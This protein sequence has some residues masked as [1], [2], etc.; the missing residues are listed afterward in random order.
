[1]NLLFLTPRP[2]EPPDRGDKIRSHHLARRLA[3][4]HRV[5]LGFLVA[6][7][8]EREAAAVAATWAASVHWVRRARWQ[9]AAGAARA[10]GTGEPLTFGYFR[11]TDLARRLRDV[12]AAERIDA[13][14]VCGS[15]MAPYVEGMDVPIVLDL[16]DVDSEKW[17]AFADASRFARQ[18]VY[19]LEHRRLR[20]REAELVERVAHTI[21]CSA[22]ERDSLVEF[23][24]GGPVSVVENGVEL[25]A[26]TSP[27]G[28]AERSGI[29]F[30]GALD[31]LPNVDGID[32][33][34][35]VVLPQVRSMLPSTTLT[36]VGRNPNRR[37]RRL[38]RLD[39]VEV[40]GGVDDPRPFVWRAA[41]AVAPL[42]LGRGVQNKVLEAM[43]AG[44]PVVA[45]R[46]AHD[47]IPTAIPGVHLES[48]DSAVGAADAVVGLLRR[49]DEARAQ[50]ARAAALVQHHHSWDDAA[51]DL[52]RVLREAVG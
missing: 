50:A 45:T 17:R 51:A 20:R 49:P 5:H 48:A 1:V 6:D 27:H 44:T 38:G 37:V 22:S 36:V 46:L 13:V 2:P 30:V 9:G 42:R 21:V 15:V 26:W 16:V 25:D 12:V 19:R 33:F 35:R 52:D 32:H 28:C 11:S 24:P 41:V 23:A 18:R 7:R 4:H 8:R 31:Y 39:G 34:A 40:V 43:A 14:V 47:G 29:V 10:L 3:H